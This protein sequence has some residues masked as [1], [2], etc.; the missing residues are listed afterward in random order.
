MITNISPARGRINAVEEAELRKPTASSQEW[1]E[2]GKG[3]LSVS[4]LSPSPE[5]VG[6]SPCFESNGALQA[7]NPYREHAKGSRAV[8]GLAIITFL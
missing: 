7:G 6:G 4:F 2:E 8:A 3:C 5:T 1:Q